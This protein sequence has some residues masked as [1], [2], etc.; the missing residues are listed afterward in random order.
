MDVKRAF[1]GLTVIAAGSILLGNSLGY[2]PWS[3]WASI[4]SLWPLLLIA[5]GIDI[6]GRSLDNTWLRALSSLLVIGGLAFGALVMTPGEFGPWVIASPFAERGEAKDFSFSEP[7]DAAVERGTLRVRGGVGKVT[8]RGGSD[9]LSAEGRTP[10]GPFVFAVEKDGAD[11][12]AEVA[13]G[14]GDVTGD[15]GDAETTISLDRQ[16]LWDLRLDAGVS[17]VRADLSDVRLS[18]VDVRM[19]VSKGTLTLGAPG[20]P[21]SSKREVGTARID[22]GVS[23]FTFRVPRDVAVRVESRSGIGSVDV[24]DGFTRLSDSGGRRVWETDG[25]ADAGRVWIVDLRNGI[26]T[27][28]IERY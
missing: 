6:I 23:S 24:G 15:F 11:V 1:E 9:L 3:V 26:S 25:F 16:V 4:L 28:R 18:A 17:D 12:D 8:L 27:V 2:L 14:S 22:T 5:A 20:Q 10:F 7:H 13:P 21:W 19:G